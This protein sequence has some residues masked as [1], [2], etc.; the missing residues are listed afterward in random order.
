MA[1]GGIEIE[2][3]GEARVSSKTRG[4]EHSLKHNLRRGRVMKK[5][6]EKAEELN[7]SRQWEKRGTPST[8]ERKKK[9]ITPEHLKGKKRVFLVRPNGQARKG[10]KGRQKA[11]RCR[12]AASIAWRKRQ[13][14]CRRDINW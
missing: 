1:G 5:G 6:G 3:K 10:G 11:A 12:S 7:L 4:R 9:G 13:G 14:F 8:L 2:E